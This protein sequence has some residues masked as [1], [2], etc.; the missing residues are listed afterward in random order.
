[1]RKEAFKNDNIAMTATNAYDLLLWD[2]TRYTDWQKLLYGGT[3]HTTNA[4]ASLSGGNAQ[5]TFR[6]GA[7]YSRTTSILTVGGADQRAS[8]SANLSNRSSDQRF[9][10][11][12][13]ATY[14]FTKSDLIGLPG[15]LSFAPNAPAIWDSTGNLN[16]AGWGG[17]TNNTS[18][19]NGLGPFGALKDPYVSKTNFLNATLSL[20]YQ[21]SKGLL[22]STDI[23]YNISQENQQYDFTIASQD[24]LNHPTGRVNWGSN[25]NNNWIIEP[26]LTYNSIISKGK[27]NVLLGGSIQQT[28]TDGILLSGSGFTSD[29]LLGT[30]S[31]AQSLVASQNSGEYKYAAIFGRI[32]YNWENKYILNLNGRRDGSSRFGPGKQ[33]GNFGSAGAAWIFTEANWIRN[34]L[35]FLSFGKLRASYGLT[36]SDGVGDYQYL[37]QYS[38]AYTFPYGGSGT[39]FPVIEANPNFHWEVNKKLEAAINL[40]FLK[41]HISLQVAYYLN[42]CGNQLIS[43]PLPQFT[44][45]ASVTANSPALVQ[46]NGW[47]FTV[48]SKVIDH[49]NFTLSLNGNVAINHNKLVSYPNFELSPYLSQLM[50]G[51]PL[52]II[53]LL[54]YKG[55]DPQT[56]QY[57]F[58]D[59]NH[60]GIIDVVNNNPVN[61]D[62]RFVY[63]LSPKFF[64]GFGADLRFKGMRLS[65]FFNF[66]KQLGINA[67]Y[68]AAAPGSLNGNQ[69]TGVLDR[70]Q[71]PGDTA[72]VN[73]F[74]TRTTGAT[75]N[76]R[77][78]SDG[79]YTDASFVRLSNVAFSYE[80]PAGFIRK[81]GIQGCNLFIHANNLFV[82]TKY[83]GVDPETRNFGGLPPTRTI[84]GGLSFN[85]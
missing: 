29:D 24:P 80:L 47:E 67:L 38:S 34:H 25:N 27:L 8:F 54:H 52:N 79:V 4:Q 30:I 53:F 84:T 56:G 13:S 76:F 51:Q 82:I 19:R 33:F 3:G 72:P 20:G 69:P 60:N 37:T 42:R 70:W 68:A 39:N 58:E 15:K 59:K 77:F 55:V 6:I 28:R 50:V 45:F 18:A 48:S 43:F 71:K 75:S 57:S 16:F 73:A 23:G 26:Q 49:K 74:S 9:S 2:T 46:N 14:S 35:T 32:T 83:K 7:S 36:G 44:G 65:L 10:T 11:S 31:N 17:N 22:L 64:G 63:N 1:M 21:L 61:G 78:Y 40:G 41:D 5:T 81:T 85:F 12:L 66:K 62:D